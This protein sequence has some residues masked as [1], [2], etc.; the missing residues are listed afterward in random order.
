MALY[1]A[2]FIASPI[3]SPIGGI[4][5]SDFP[6]SACRFQRQALRTSR[7]AILAVCFSRQAYFNDVASRV[8]TGDKIKVQP[9]NQPF[10]KTLQRSF[11]DNF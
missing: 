7:E 5:V 9:A 1:K 11:F 6:R 10:L 2:I 8:S 4:F 3:Y